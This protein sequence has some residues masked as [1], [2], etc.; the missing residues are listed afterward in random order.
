M[1]VRIVRRVAGSAALALCAALLILSCGCSSPRVWATDEPWQCIL[2]AGYGYGKIQ[3]MRRDG[4]AEWEMESED[5]TCD[6]WMLPDGNIV[7]SCGRNGTKIVKPDYEDGE[8]GEIVWHRP[9]SRE[10]GESHSC[11]PLGDGRF[12]IGESY[13]GV[14]YVLEVDTEGNEYKRIELK[15]IGDHPHR[16]FR[17]IRKTPQ[18]TY[19]VAGQGKRYKGRQAMEVDA[20]GKTI[21]R[22]P[23]GGYAAIRLPN[24]NT[25]LSSGDRHLGDCVARLFEVDPEGNIVWKLEHDDLLPEIQIGYSAGVQRLPNGNTLV[26]NG[27]YHLDPD[28]DPGPAVFE[29]TPEKEI[30]WMC[31]DS[32]AN[33]VTSVM[34]LDDVRKQRSLR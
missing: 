8:G 27:R 6:A 25:L 29:I 11:Q 1:G 20:E 15:G 23:G 31:P 21:R 4:T 7:Y 19:L 10:N 3:I 24:G 33:Y 16:T 28:V 9:L 32:M 12:L 18:G 5:R 26:C 30:V 22:Y 34:V 17:V 14:S 13:A 2:V